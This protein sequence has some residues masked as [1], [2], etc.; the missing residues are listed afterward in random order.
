MTKRIVGFVCAG[1][2]AGRFLVSPTLASGLIDK[3]GNIIVFLLCLLLFFVGLDIGLDDKVLDNV[4]AAGWR[5]V[6]FPFATAA[7]SLLGG[8]AG[9]FFL[10]LSVRDGMAV[11]AGLGWY[12]LAP[13]MLSSYSASISA[14]AFIH[15]LFRVMSATVLIPV[16]AK[17]IGAVECC[18]LPGGASMDICILIIEKAA[19]SN[20]AIYAFVHGAVLTVLI[21]IMVALVAGV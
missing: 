16:V 15:N 2:L 19:G 8:I 14:I 12:S 13:V 5:V 11:C 3:I 20:A 9:S 1:L 6:L 21:P 18:C 10:P 7:G 17:R 4:K